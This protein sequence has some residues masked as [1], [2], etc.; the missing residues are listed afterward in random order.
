MDEKQLTIEEFPAIDDG[1]WESILLEEERNSNKKKRSKDTLG[2]RNSDNHLNWDYAVEVFNRDQRIHLSVINFNKGGLLV[3]WN[4]IN[5]F[6]PCSHLIDLP[7]QLTKED[8]DRSLSSYVGKSIC[9]KIIECLPGKGRL[10]FSERAAQTKSGRRTELMNDLQVGQRVFGNVTNITDFGVFVDL[11]GVEGLIHLSELSWG[12]VDHPSM[13][14]EVGQKVNVLI[15]EIQ[16]DRCRVALSLKRLVPNPWVGVEK[17][18]HENQ[19][20]PA[21]ITSLTSYGAFALLDDCIEGLIHF[22]EIPLKDKENIN[23]YLKPGDKI[24][25]KVL[26]VDI[27][28][29][30]LGLSLNFDK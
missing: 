4:G 18:Y 17:K 6:I 16:P 9:V 7:P 26:K 28:R 21:Q 11:G 3:D 30:R 22:S 23:D 25:V 20:V 27:S 13:V 14:L 19:I 29:Q 8:R 12:R 10:V 24:L 2:R 5:G 1:W 15:L